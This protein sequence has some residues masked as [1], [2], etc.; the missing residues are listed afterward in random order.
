MGENV[1]EFGLRILASETSFIV[2]L[3]SNFII[4]QDELL[5][6]DTFLQA[7]YEMLKCFATETVGN[8]GIPNLT[9]NYLLK[10]DISVKN[11]LENFVARYKSSKPQL[12]K[13]EKN[14]QKIKEGEW[15]CVLPS[16]TYLDTEQIWEIYQELDKLNGK[17]NQI[18]IP[19]LKEYNM[20][21]YGEKPHTNIGHQDKN[22]RKCRWCGRTVA[23]GATFNKKAHAI[24]EALGNKNVVLLDECDSCN[25]KFGKTVEQSITA[26][27]IFFNT[28]F[29]IHGKN[30][31]SK[32][33]D[34]KT[35][36]SIEHTKEK[37]LTFK[38]YGNIMSFTSKV[39]AGITLTISNNYIAQ[40]VY[41]SLCKYAL[42]VVEDESIL[43]EF[44]DTIKWLNGEIIW[45]KVPTVKL[46]NTYELFSE[47]PI[48][49]IYLRKTDNTKYPKMFAEFRHTNIVMVYII[50]TSEQE[51]DMFIDENN[52][53]N[54]W[55]FTF[56]KN[57]DNWIDYDFSDRNKKELQLNMKF[58]K[59]E[60]TKN[61]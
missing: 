34:I 57:I 5:G 22:L 60:E 51:N 41:K 14:V 2:N 48:I 28:I 59:N 55:N 49:N 32:I 39:P 25:E 42:S 24:T 29:G 47:Q 10:Y 18:S 27:F 16:N 53:K 61:D 58:N 44:S 40:D 38:V 35:Q 13:L 45:S 8:D 23:M 3:G 12:N 26:Q 52:F 9:I 37:E 7:L 33:K 4:N 50:P 43:S 36:T 17:D 21:S 30:G 6:E 54:F 46:F 19:V 56:F 11:K 1:S 31:I 15:I 20:Y